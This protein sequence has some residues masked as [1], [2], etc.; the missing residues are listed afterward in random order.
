MSEGTKQYSRRTVLKTTGAATLATTGF[1]AS[2][3]TAAAATCDGSQAPT[4][5]DT[6][7]TV[8]LHAAPNADQHGK[9]SDYATYVENEFN[10]H[11]SDFNLSVTVYDDNLTKSEIRNYSSDSK[12]FYAFADY[13]RETIYSG[14][15]S[16]EQGDVDVYMYDSSE[17]S[18]TI[19]AGAMYT[20]GAYDGAASDS[21]YN[22]YPVGVASGSSNGDAGCRIKHEL[23]HGFFY[24]GTDEYGYNQSDHK[25]MNVSNGGT[26]S[27]GADCRELGDL[28]GKFIDWAYTNSTVYY[29]GPDC[30]YKCSP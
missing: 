10:D 1:A 11:V 13:I 17:W 30:V 21:F 15:W 26:C 19:G 5:Q 4:P 28:S 24:Q 12:P 7:F 3:G 14:D 25:V 6:D 27:D 23:T 16:G 29:N 2:A 9:L 18:D 8:W 20:S 22:P